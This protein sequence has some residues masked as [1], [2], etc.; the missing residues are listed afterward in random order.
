MRAGV[1]SMRLPGGTCCRLTW[2]QSSVAPPTGSL[3]SRPLPVLST[4]ISA[5]AFPGGFSGADFADPD[6]PSRQ[7]KSGHLANFVVPPNSNQYYESVGKSPLMLL[8]PKK[9]GQT[10]S[11]LP[12]QAPVNAIVKSSING[13]TASATQ[14]GPVVVGGIVQVSCWRCFLSDLPVRVVSSCAPVWHGRLWRSVCCFCVRLFFLWSAIHTGL[15]CWIT[16]DKNNSKKV[17]AGTEWFLEMFSSEWFKVMHHLLIFAKFWFHFSVL[18]PR[19]NFQ[20]QMDTFSH[21]TVA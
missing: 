4:A 8:P 19:K 13:P 3:N 2:P 5:A 18:N 10:M 6:L 20:I 16:P 12:G 21:S 11:F 17:S 15:M 1:A 9:D 7:K 14:I